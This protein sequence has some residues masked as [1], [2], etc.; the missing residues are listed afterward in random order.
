M[1][2]RPSAASA[3]ARMSAALLQRMRTRSRG[4]LQTLGESVMR[5]GQW[6]RNSEAFSCVPQ[7]TRRSFCVYK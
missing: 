4:L 6:Q 1:T 2:A 5:M 3:F 7:S